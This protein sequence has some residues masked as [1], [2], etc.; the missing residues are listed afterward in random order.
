MSRGG[1]VLTLTY[2]GAQRVTPNYNVMGV[3]KAAL[4]SAVRYL[5]NDLGPEGIRVNAISP[6]PM[7]TLAGAAIAG[8]RKV[9]RATE[10][11]TP[12]RANATLEA[13]GGT[14]V[15]LASD[16][17][18][19]HHRRGDL[20]RRRLP[21]PRHGAA[22]VSRERAPRHRTTALPCCAPLRRPSC[23]RL[24]GGGH[25][26][27]V[28]CLPGLTRDARTSTT[29]PPRSRGR[30]P[31]DPPDVPRPRRLG[32]RPGG[33]NYNVAV[34]ARD[35]VEL[36]D[37]LG[38][39]A[40]SRSSAPRA[41]GS[42]RWCWRRRQGPRLAGVLLN[43]VGPELAPEGLAAIMTYLGDRR[44]RRGLP[45]GRRGPEGADGAGLPRAR[46]RAL[47]GAGPALVRRGR[48][49]LALN[50]DP[51]LR[52]A[53]EAVVESRR[54]TSGRSST[55]SRACRWRWCAGRTPTCFQPETRP[56]MRERRPDLI[57]AEV[58]D[59]GH[60]PF[61]DEPEALRALEALLARVQ[62]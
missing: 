16:L 59:R 29:S 51:R 48:R 3:A 38:L 27:P 62:A 56:R 37:H 8:A 43:D 10:L 31:A 53:F 12:L 1:S 58:P 26:P 41:A 47:G 11:N 42:S 22:R 55:R 60:V 25:R 61:L 54:P 19:L 46:R 18:R 5:A 15:Y 17:A 49:R 39:A 50:Y 40:W 7:R 34:E 32:P 13:V 52:D 6:G 14:A 36:L 35:V 28:L 4:E 9:Y 45:R 57:F 21:R 24:G 44:R 30:P 23:A 2:I 33:R 20:R